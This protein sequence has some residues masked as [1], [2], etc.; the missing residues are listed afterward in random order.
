MALI[1]ARAGSKGVPQKNTMVF[2]GKS[3]IQR[4]IDCAKGAPIVDKIVVNSD[5]QNILDTTS[6]LRD[7]RI[8]KQLRPHYLGNDNSS[9]V[10]VA[11][12][13]IEQLNED[14]DIIVLLQVTSP[15]RSSEDLDE[16]ITFFDNDEKL[17]GVISVVPVEDQHPARMY[18]IE[19]NRLVPLNTK[20][21]NKHRQNLKKVFLRNGCFYAIKTDALLKQ[22]TFMPEY[23]KP[24][25]MN[26]E[27]LLN[28][29]SPRDVIIGK[30]LIKS[31]D[32]KEI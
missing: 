30:A 17:E 6:E 22:K 14:F 8:T 10:D 32:N 2:E 19:D 7:L 15:L 1:P 3:L 31:W 28:I 9:I 16:I 27:H 11:I 5:D 20:S 18:N 25:I 26:P 4:A 23:K 24:F 29:D 21:E 12:H 13:A